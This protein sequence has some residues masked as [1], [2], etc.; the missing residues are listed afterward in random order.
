MVTRNE[1]SSTVGGLI[2]WCAHELER[3]SPASTTQ[4]RSSIR[5]LSIHACCRRR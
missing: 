5:S 2:D 4:P 3:V 1:Y